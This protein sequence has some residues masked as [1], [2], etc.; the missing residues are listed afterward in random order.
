LLFTGKSKNFRVFGF[1]Y[2]AVLF[3]FLILRGK[4]Y[5]MAGLYPFM[6]AAG[7]VS[8]EIF[9]KS[10]RWRM[11]FLV[12]IVLLSIPIVPGGIPILPAGKLAG[13][14]AKIPE[15]MG[16]EA[17]LRWEDGRMH[18]LPQDFADMLGWDELGNIVI[19][20]CDS[21]RDKNR[22]M[23]YAENYGQ[24][25][26][27][28]HYGKS[29]GLPAVASFSDS[30]LMWAPDSVAPGIDM[31]F[32]VNDELGSDIDSLFARVDSVGSITNPYAREHGTT[33]YLCRSPRAD[34]RS[35]WSAR[36]KDV[37]QVNFGD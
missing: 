8:W 1:I 36:V 4:S 15:Q 17:L 5:Y 18:S 26:A 13:F 16:K 3:M 22:I 33:V 10:A 31:F 27:I 28:E 34:F 7:G 21:I 30:Y 20:A 11:A 35:F 6:F 9:I 29:H 23:I 25:G 32:Y 2:V 12:L 37:K 24:A 19:Q 14:Y